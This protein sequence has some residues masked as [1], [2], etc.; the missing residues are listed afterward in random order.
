MTVSLEIVCL[1]PAHTVALGHFFARVAGDPKSSQFHPHPFSDSEAERICSL[2]GND[3]Y[4]ALS[5]DGDFLGYGMLRG[6]DEGFSIP[7]LGIYV[8]PELRGTGAARLMMQHLHLI[9][10]LAG[11][12]Q[13]RLKVYRENFSAYRLYESMGYLFTDSNEHGDQLVGILSL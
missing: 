13:V 12:T 6:W 4:V 8:A 10:R 5:S 9:A 2:V 1:V 3:K 7:S 11:A